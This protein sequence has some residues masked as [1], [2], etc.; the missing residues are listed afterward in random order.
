MVRMDPHPEICTS[1][2]VLFA[3]WVN[4]YRRHISGELV[5]LYNAVSSMNCAFWTGQKIQR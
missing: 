1:D 4:S 2:N 5:P 3:T